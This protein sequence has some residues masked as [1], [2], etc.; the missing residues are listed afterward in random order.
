MELLQFD[1]IKNLLELSKTEADYPS[2]TLLEASSLS[3][4]EN[5]LRRTLKA[6][7]L[8]ETFPPALLDLPLK[9]LPVNNVVSVVRDSES[10]TED[11]DY[12]ITPYGLAVFLVSYT[13]PIVVTYNGGYTTLPNDLYRAL[14]M[15]TAYE[16]QNRDHIG[17]IS[18]SNEGGAVQRPE[19][20]LLKEVLRILEPY[21]HPLTGIW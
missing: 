16:W 2:L 18:V 4:I 3:A 14:L 13:K 8:V 19:L 10:L 12:L 9:A 6:D 7:D 20:G 1:D 21:K 17:A 15:Q 5:H 11:D